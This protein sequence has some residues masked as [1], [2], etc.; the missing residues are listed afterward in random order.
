MR[1][2]NSFSNSDSQNILKRAREPVPNN[3][4]TLSKPQNS[5]QLPLGGISYF[6]QRV[7]AQPLS[8]PPVEPSACCANFEL[9]QPDTNI[10]LAYNSVSPELS[11][12][13]GRPINSEH[14]VNEPVN[15]ERSLKTSYY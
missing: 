9:K 15:Q 2:S 8:L 4:K 10:N 3:P 1:F 11:A 13:H 7:T 6:N 12:I 5:H 14:L